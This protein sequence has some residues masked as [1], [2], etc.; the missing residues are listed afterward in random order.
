[1]EYGISEIIKE[2]GLT[3]SLILTPY[4]YPKGGGGIKKPEIWTPGAKKGQL[5]PKMLRFLAN[6]HLKN[7]RMTLNSDKTYNILIIINIILK[8]V[9]FCKP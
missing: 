4:S 3:Y 7:R 5:E 2:H 8:S 6:C 1:M 9:N